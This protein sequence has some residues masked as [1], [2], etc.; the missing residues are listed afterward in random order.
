[1][2]TD[3]TTCN[4]NDYYTPWFTH[5]H[6]GYFLLLA[7]Q[8]RPTAG[9]PRLFPPQHNIQLFLQSLQHFGGN[10][11]HCDKCSGFFQNDLTCT[12]IDCGNQGVCELGVC[13]C[14]DGWR[15]N[16]CQYQ[17][18][19]NVQACDARTN[20]TVCLSNMCIECADGT[21]NVNNQCQPPANA[22]PS[23]TP[24]RSAVPSPST[25]HAP[26]PSP[27]TPS[28]TAA[29]PSST[30]ASGAAPSPI[31]V[32]APSSSVVAATPS[33]ESALQTPSTTPSPT[34]SAVTPVTQ[35]GL[36]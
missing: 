26:T 12:G 18:C 36:C 6:L 4:T 20:Q 3:T 8:L 32:A 28:S 29:T 19:D 25:L 27:T 22:A 31:P 13:R 2:Y 16:S 10:G 35:T 7:V 23:P 33:P 17:T 5:I 14:T 24:R 1:M 34:P 15:G 30:P 21:Y 9:I 11:R